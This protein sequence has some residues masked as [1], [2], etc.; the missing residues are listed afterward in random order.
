MPKDYYKTLGIDKSAT[1]D[2]IK[3]AFRKLAHEYHP[4]KGTGNEA[5]FKEVSEAYSVLSDDK[6]RSQYD[7]FG[8]AGP[9]S[10]AGQSYGGGYGGFGNGFEGFDFSQFNQGGNGQN[11]EFDLGDIF[12]DIFGGGRQSR[13]KKGKDIQVDLD[14]TFAE[15]IF[16][17]EKEITITKNS[18]C[19]DCGGSGAKK[20][21]ETS[22]CDQCN[23]R[24][25][26]KEAR[27]SVFGS[28]MTEKI[29]DK[30][31]GMGKIAK[32]KCTTCHGQGISRS[33]EK[34]KIKVPTDIDDGETMSLSGAGEAITGGIPG[35]LYIQIHVKKDKAFK[36]EGK[37]LV[38]ELTVKL[39]DA[40]LGAEYDLKILDG[41]I[42]VKIPEGIKFGEI[43][44]IRGRG[45]PKERDGRGDLLIKINIQT[46]SRLSKTAR[47]A[48]EDLKKEGI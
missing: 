11:F 31:S 27:R 22:T 16:G 5:K 18:S 25:K 28:I 8:S 29:C 38:T 6:K 33:T 24:G 4:D 43:L 20:G 37:D 36:K 45:I 46:P 2:D 26:V 34:F 47:K 12:G 35:D 40:L 10:S 42:K 44:R 14:L 17:V 21:T 9:S 39:S 3:K 15:S 23:G 41:D 30:C 32:E 1:K 19:K 7:T 13:T 48:I